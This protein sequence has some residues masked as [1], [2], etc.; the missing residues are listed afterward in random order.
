M[1]FKPKGDQIDRFLLKSRLEV[2]VDS[3]RK[4]REKIMHVFEKLDIFRD[5]CYIQVYDFAK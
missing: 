2:G 3:K 5:C 1:I 4:I